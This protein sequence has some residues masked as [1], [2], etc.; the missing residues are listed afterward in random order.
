MTEE[1]LIAPCGIN[2]GLCSNYL[3]MKYDLK[4]KGVNKS[5]CPGCLN[6]G[7]NCYYES[8]C[9]RLGKKLI[10]F[11][12]DCADYPCRLIKTL[13]K[14]YRTHYRLSVIENLEFIREHGVAPFLARETEKW[15]CPECGGVICCH[16]G[17]CFNCGLEKLRQKRCKYRWED[18]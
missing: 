17:I 9:P 5:Y 8:K 10:R 1:R 3:A 12:Y 15:R 18:S 2:C 16:N 14:R 11:C 4:K 7:R 6:N 13:D